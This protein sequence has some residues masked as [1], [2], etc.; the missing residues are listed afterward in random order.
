MS[1]QFKLNYFCHI[2]SLSKIGLP[3]KDWCAEQ[4][5]EVSATSVFETSDYTARCILQ[6]IHGSSENVVSVQIKWKTD[7]QVVVLLIS[8]N[9]IKFVI[10]IQKD[11]CTPLIC[12]YPQYKI[13]VKKISEIFLFHGYTSIGFKQ[14][15]FFLFSLQV[16]SVNERMPFTNHASR[17]LHL[18]C[19]ETSVKCK[20]ASFHHGLF[21]IS[22][23]N[24]QHKIKLFNVQDDVTE[25]D[26]ICNVIQ[27]KQVIMCCLQEMKLET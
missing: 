20:L 2:T 24:L 21:E 13:I 17:V 26:I 15:H 5:E 6:I 14:K 18:Y 19:K 11:K 23:V 1:P 16:M 7:C 22:K 27:C 9:Y 3:H 12:N 4:V 25:H 10:A 8:E